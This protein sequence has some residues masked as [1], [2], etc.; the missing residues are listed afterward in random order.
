[1]LTSNTWSLTIAISFAFHLAIVTADSDA[2]RAVEPVTCDHLPEFLL[3]GT[4]CSID[5]ICFFGKRTDCPGYGQYP[6]SKCVCSSK[7]RSWSCV[8]ETCPP[9]SKFEFKP[10]SGCT[11]NGVADLSGNHPLC[12]LHFPPEENPSSGCVPALYGEICSYG[13]EFWYDLSVQSVSLCLFAGFQH[14]SLKSSSP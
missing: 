10:A 14:S 2:F 11:P 6:K 3:N 4:I 1:M 5:K 12:P 7:T 13:S 8:T 9:P